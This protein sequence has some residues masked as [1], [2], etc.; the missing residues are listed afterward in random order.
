MSYADLT[1][2]KALERAL[3]IEA[4]DR[5]EEEDKKLLFSAI[6]LNEKSELVKSIN[7]LVRTLQTN[8]SNKQCNQKFSS[9]KVRRKRV[10]PS[11]QKE[12]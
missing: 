8:L 7:S 11:T 5:I 9:Q 6:Q 1:S 4:L 3:R 12:R 10:M 2:D